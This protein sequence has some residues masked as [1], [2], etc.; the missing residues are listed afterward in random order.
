MKTIF[1]PELIIDPDHITID[2]PYFLN[3]LTNVLR[4]TPETEIKVNTTGHWFQGKI[5]TI[6]Q[7]KIV[8]MIEKQGDIKDETPYII[9]V[10]SLIKWSR[11][12][13]IIEKAVEL[14]VREIH[15][16][17]TERTVIKEFNWAK[18]MIRWEKIMLKAL[19]QS[20]QDTLPILHEPVTINSLNL[21]ISNQIFFDT[22]RKNLTFNGKI[23]DNISAPVAL[24]IG[25]E[26]GF[27]PK[28]KQILY[29]KGFTGYNLDFPILRSETASIVAI[30]LMRFG[31]KS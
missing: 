5:S 23:F 13:W 16:L 22:D 29:H 8:M 31:L 30:T 1:I 7:K 11:L 12:E 24:C 28:E 10:Q 14:G 21:P 15:F 9:L 2:L 17:T 6:T 18:K 19:T 4:M 20:Q 27:S 3:Y 25:P 26:G